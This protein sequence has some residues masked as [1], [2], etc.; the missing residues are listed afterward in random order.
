MRNL[1]SL[2]LFVCCSLLS[3][4]F[5]RAQKPPMPRL[6]YRVS[7]ADPQSHAYQVSM[8][9][10]DW[11]SDTLDLFLPNWMPGDYQMRDYF[12]G[13]KNFNLLSGRVLD[14]SQKA[15]WKVVRNGKESVRLAYEVATNS[16]LVANS[17]VDA[18]RAYIVP[19]KSFL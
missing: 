19:V 17:Y 7:V 14:S 8:E 3:P 1:P 4:F 10:K 12:K 2:A 9:I 13:I 18:D 5:T 11:P 15:H 6:E 16:N